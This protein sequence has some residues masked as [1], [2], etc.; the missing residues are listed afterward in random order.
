[1]T[2][3][4]QQR[5]N[6]FVDLFNELDDWLF[7]YE[8]LMS[9]AGDMKP[10]PADKKDNTHLVKGCQSKAWVW[11]TCDNGKLGVRAD[12]EALIIKGMIGVV[13]DLLDGANLADAASVNIDFISRTSLKDQITADRFHGMQRVIET[14]QGFAR[15][16]V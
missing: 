13:V 1:M 9:I 3:S 14:M 8:L 4:L 7:Q 16:H 11:C 5:Q 12:S 6:D 10:Y 2:A 15:K